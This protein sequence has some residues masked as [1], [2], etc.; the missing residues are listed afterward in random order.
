[1]TWVDDADNVL[2]K[3]EYVLYGTIPTYDSE[4]PTKEATAQYTYTFTGWSP[5][6][7]AVEGDVT[8][9]AVFDS[10]VNNYLITFKNEDGT[11]LQSG[12]VAYGE[13]PEYTGETPTKEATA[14]HTFTF[15]Y[16]TPA[17]EPVTGEATY[18]ATFGN[19]IN[20][21]TL[22]FSASRDIL[23]LCSEG[24]SFIRSDSLD[25]AQVEIP[26]PYPAIFVL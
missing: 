11:V 19:T 26:A 24:K 12:L 16:W 17:V 8:Y 18:A 13:M 25:K 9:K 4:E 3:D 20:T 22:A 14:Q 5:A 21:Y 7:A 6:I 1:V 10:T 2:E 15:K 23:Y